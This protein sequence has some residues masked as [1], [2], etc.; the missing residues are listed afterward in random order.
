MF[1]FF[2]KFWK[3][4]KYIGLHFKVHEISIINLVN[5]I[6]LR[7]FTFGISHCYVFLLFLLYLNNDKRNVLKP[8]IFTPLLQTIT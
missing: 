1:I 8:F 2:F 7:A 6:F 3:A 5:P 4:N